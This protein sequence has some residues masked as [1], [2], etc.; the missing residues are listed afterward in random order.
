MKD[1][2]ASTLIEQ[3]K[4]AMKGAWALHYDADKRNVASNVIDKNGGNIPPLPSQ[5][6]DIG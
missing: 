2:N 5:L 6:N 1:R 3:G 4:G